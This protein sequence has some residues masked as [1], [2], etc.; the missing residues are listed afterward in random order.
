MRTEEEANR[1]VE[2]YADM[3][4]RICFLNLKNYVDTEDIFQTVFM[5]YVLYSGVFESEEHEKSWII[6]VT[7]NA[8]KDFLKCFY[9]KNMVLTAYIDENTLIESED[10]G[11]E[12]ERN[13]HVME[14]V[15]SLPDKYKKVIYLF[16]YE[17]YT[18]AQIGKILNK[19]ENTV[20][21]HL[22]RGKKMLKEILGGEVIG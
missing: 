1:A 15:L 17:G 19:N 10:K 21:T 13:S 16:Y 4:K 7:M 12:K 20:Y 8:C 18:A 3:V 14:A 6:Q 5:K 2:I 22:S 9:R 11:Y